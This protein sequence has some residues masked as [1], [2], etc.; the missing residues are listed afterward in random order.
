MLTLA[1]HTQLGSCSDISALCFCARALRAITSNPLPMAVCTYIDCICCS[2]DHTQRILD[3]I[4]SQ[5]PIHRRRDSQVKRR[6][7]ILRPQD[8][9]FRVLWYFRRRRHLLEIKQRLRTLFVHESSNFNQFDGTI[10]GRRV[11]R[12]CGDTRPTYTV[13]V[14]R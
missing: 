6:R 13:H 2:N 4:P 8:R 7:F 5:R 11:Q 9:S 12:A 3:I 14:S 10:G 1:N